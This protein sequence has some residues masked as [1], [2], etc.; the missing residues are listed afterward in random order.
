MERR[1]YMVEICVPPLLLVYILGPRDSIKEKYTS[2]RSQKKYYFFQNGVSWPLHQSD[3][4]V[5]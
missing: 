4:H 1:K 5:H 3:G 2:I